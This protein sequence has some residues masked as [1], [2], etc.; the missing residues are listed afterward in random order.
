M[1]GRIRLCRYIRDCKEKQFCRSS[2]G[3]DKT[4]S[5]QII[6]WRCLC[7]S[8]CSNSASS[9][10][11]SSTKWHGMFNTK[12]CLNSLTNRLFLISRIFRQTVDKTRLK[13]AWYADWMNEWGY[14]TVFVA[15][16]E[17][18]DREKP[19]ND[20]VSFTESVT[21][22]TDSGLK[23]P[24]FVKRAGVTPLPRVWRTSIYETENSE[25]FSFQGEQT[26]SFTKPALCV[27]LNKW[28]HLPQ[29]CSSAPSEHSW[30]PLQCAVAGR[31][32]WLEQRKPLHRVPSGNIKNNVNE[33]LLLR[34]SYCFYDCSCL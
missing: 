10:I 31:Q 33:A 27:L 16:K 12:V 21:I 6:S 7:S 9:L 29:L 30:I 15:L 26:Q 14:E 8:L 1:R 19:A 25:F 3:N 11:K 13:Y 2:R 18:G 5:L 34:E 24:L 28:D 17:G 32:V 4:S 20:Q 23:L 22:A